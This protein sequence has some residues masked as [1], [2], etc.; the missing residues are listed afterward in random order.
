[1]LRTELCK[2]QM[3]NMEM[4]EPDEVRRLGA[5]ESEIRTSID[6]I[7]IICSLI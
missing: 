7:V 3:R 4:P 6:T 1:M 5:K 2:Y